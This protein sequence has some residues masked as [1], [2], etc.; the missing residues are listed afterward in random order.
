M[1][2]R[3][4]VGLLTLGASFL[5]L[6]SAPDSRVNGARVSAAYGEVTVEKLDS[7]EIDIISADWPVARGDRL[8]TEPASHAEMTLGSAAV[9]LDEET[10]VVVTALESGATKLRLQ[11]GVIDIAVRQLL[12]DETFDVIMPG[13]TV[14]L[15]STGDYRFTL[16]EDRRATVVV[17]AGEA[18]VVAGLASFQQLPGEKAHIGSDGTVDIEQTQLTSR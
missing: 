1:K 17:R 18:Q 15:R 12:P 7:H 16:F 2:T 8:M 3:L 14:H 11:F 13:C 9:R 10:D 5:A 4:A 6:G